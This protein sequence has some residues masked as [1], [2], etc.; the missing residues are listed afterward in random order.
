MWVKSLKLVPG[1]A[2][3]QTR[4]HA[5]LVD[6]PLQVQFMYRA[7]MALEMTFFRRQTQT[8]SVPNESNPG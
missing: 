6:A 3:A 4:N 7:L 8:N 5:K 2:N 1:F